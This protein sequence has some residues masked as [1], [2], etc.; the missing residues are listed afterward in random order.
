M[1]SAALWKSS[2]DEAEWTHHVC[3]RVC[4]WACVYVHVRECV[5]AFVCVW[6]NWHIMG[7]AQKG[8]LTA[9]RCGQE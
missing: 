6:A 9:F 1:V 4:L 2:G 7:R 8:L 5:C 3:A